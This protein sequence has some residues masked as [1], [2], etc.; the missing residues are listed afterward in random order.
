LR[1]VPHDN[2]EA[3][4]ANIAACKQEILEGESYEICLTTELRAGG[5]VDPLAAYLGLRVEN[6]APYGALFRLGGVSVLSSSPERFLQVG[7]DRV[8]QSKPIKGT[9]ARAG[10]PVQ[11]ALA[12]SSLTRDP[13][14]LSENLMI[15]DLVRNDLG[16]VAEMGSVQVPALMRVESYATVHQLVTTVQAKLRPDASAIDCVRASFPGGS[17]TGAPKLRTMEII[18]HLEG[19]PRGVYSGALGYLS[20]NGTVDL[21]IVIR[22]IVQA[23]ECLTIGAGGAIVALSDSHEELR[24]MQLK[25]A[26]L[27]SAVGAKLVSPRRLARLWP[28]RSE[29][30]AAGD[31]AR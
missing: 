26:P 16:R 31:A 9:A 13:K 19:R 17:M 6:P 27:I 28:A 29:P 5:R 8:A 21:S 7:R 24:E 14:S 10:N 3:Y 2:D 1:F 25:A 11:D 12:A 22:T 23:G 30:L 15:A 18:D 4:L 20:V